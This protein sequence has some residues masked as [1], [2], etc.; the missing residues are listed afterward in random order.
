MKALE[1]ITRTIF[2][3]FFGSHILATLCV[4]V[5]AIAPA[6]WVP[7]PLTDL[8]VWYASSLK[9]PLMSK[10]A[11]LPW[12]QSLICLELIFQLP[13]FFWA[14]VELTSNRKGTYKFP[15]AK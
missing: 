1:G 12:F 10:P 6:A 7:Q 13:F 14:V 11:E 4:D 8:L 2:L 9:D 15:I 3:G 5:Q